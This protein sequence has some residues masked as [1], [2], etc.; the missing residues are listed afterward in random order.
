MT[1]DKLAV[2]K[3]SKDIS[4]SDSSLHG[5]AKRDWDLRR[6]GK[7]IIWP[8]FETTLALI[9]SVGAILN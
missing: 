4:F 9:M 3:N 6:L 8:P 2:T 1:R 5:W 7:F